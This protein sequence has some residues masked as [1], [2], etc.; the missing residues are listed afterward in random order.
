MPRPRQTRT[1]DTEPHTADSSDAEPQTATPSEESAARNVP[2]FGAV[3]NSARTF[4][5]YRVQS[6]GKQERCALPGA[7]GADVDELPIG[8]LS[9]DALRTFGPGIYRARYFRELPSGKR[10]PCGQSKQIQLRLPE[11]AA[12]TS[13]APAGYDVARMIAEAEARAEARS[14]QMLDFVLAQQSAKE[15]QQGDFFAAMMQMQ[16]TGHAQQLE[17]MQRA[18]TPAAAGI[19]PEFVRMQ[20]DLAILRDRQRRGE[21]RPLDDD[22]DDADPAMRLLESPV[23]SELVKVFAAKFMGESAT[24]NPAP[25]AA[26][27]VDAPEDDEADPA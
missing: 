6:D 13:A 4:A 10:E 5:F 8:Q 3:P 18:K 15:R 24:P 14:R 26:T 9:V 23:I 11:A 1:A 17:I 27:I 12:A 20:T 16:Q 22:D 21:S 25:T 2:P 7:D 19:S